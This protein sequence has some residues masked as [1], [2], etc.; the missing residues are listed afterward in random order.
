MWVQY[1]P[2][3]LRFDQPP[4]L[5]RHWRM[6][7][8]VTCPRHRRFLMDRCPT[9]RQ[10][11]AGLEGRLLVPL[12][13]CGHCGG[14]L[15]NAEKLKVPGATRARQMEAAMIR[16]LDADRELGVAGKTGLAEALLRLPT[17]VANKGT[18]SFRQLST[19]ARVYAAA[20][21]I[22]IDRF[23]M[24]DFPEVTQARC[25]VLNALSWPSR[26]HWIAQVGSLSQRGPWHVAPAP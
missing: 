17:L 14:D 19:A 16:F 22:V 8:A 2:D 15:T 1:C 21:P 26:P 18:A 4:F 12:D 20:H 24:S 9:C 25:A 10:G 7:W 5:R 6:T 13:R 11:L 3:C 23:V